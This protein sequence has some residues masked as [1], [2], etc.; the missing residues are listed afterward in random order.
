MTRGVFFP[1]VKSACLP[2]SVEIL[3]EG[4]FAAQ[5]AL[6][7][8][9]FEAGSKLLR[10]EQHGFDSCSSLS[11]ICL[12]SCVERL[13]DCCFYG[14]AALSSVTFEAS[15]AL[16]RIELFA[17]CDSSSLSS[18][19]IPAALLEIG[20]GAF[21]YTR[22]GAISIEDGSCHFT[23]ADGLLV[24]LDDSSVV[25]Y[26]GRSEAIVIP[27]DVKSLGPYCL[28]AN[29][30]VSSVTFEAGSKLSSVPAACWAP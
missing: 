13:C 7:S 9:T 18:I 1:P 28:Y 8:L 10:I 27:R 26:Y 22:L 2:S 24:G 3:G 30:V 12:P 15:S 14:C 16:S 23:I 25:T 4:C 20:R 11:S 6:S 5:S 29:D 21:N 17:F 19:Y